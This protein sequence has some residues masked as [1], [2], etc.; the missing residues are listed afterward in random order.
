MIDEPVYLR[1]PEYCY[2]LRSAP[3]W[4]MVTG[5]ITGERQLVA[6]ANLALIFD[7]QGQFLEVYGEASG[8]A[9]PIPKSLLPENFQDRGCSAELATWVRRLEFEQRPIFVRRFWLPEPWIGISDV[10]L[11]LWDL[12]RDPDLFTEKQWAEVRA[13]E[14]LEWGNFAFRCGEFEVYIGREGQDQLYVTVPRS[15]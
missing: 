4:P 8:Q 1:P 15:P 9:C 13:S 6:V 11:M 5:A 14:W 2:C 7:D 12:P 10:P 3:G